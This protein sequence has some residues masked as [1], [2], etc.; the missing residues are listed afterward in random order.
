MSLFCFDPIL[1]VHYVGVLSVYNTGA[2][3]ELR[4]HTRRMPRAR[5]HF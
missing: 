4:L 2:V 3:N 5:I 1:C